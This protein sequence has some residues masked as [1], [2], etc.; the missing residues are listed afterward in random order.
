[1]FVAVV[2]DGTTGV[3]VIDGIVEFEAADGLREVVVVV[4]DFMVV[5]AVIFKGFCDE[6]GVTDL[7][8]FVDAVGLAVDGFLVD[9]G[10]VFDPVGRIVTAPSFIGLFPSSSEFSS[11]SFCA[12]DIDESLIPFELPEELSEDV[13]ELF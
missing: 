1:M 5:F 11:V 13:F 3:V 8:F 9:L 7:M 10:V 4:L 2:S 6:V 12:S